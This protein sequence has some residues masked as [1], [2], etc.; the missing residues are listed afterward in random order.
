MKK[1]LSRGD[2]KVESSFP[3]DEDDAITLAISALKRNE[4]AIAGCKKAVSCLSE[5][6]KCEEKFSRETKMLR[7]VRIASKVILKILEGEE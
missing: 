7:G 5:T 4:A 2:D 6:I 3:Q 1:E